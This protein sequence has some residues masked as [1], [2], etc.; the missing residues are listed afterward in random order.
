MKNHS[1]RLDEE[2]KKALFKAIEGV[3]GEVYLFG[4]RVDPEKRGGDVDLLI[5]TDKDPFK[6]SLEIST[7]YFM[8]C[9]EK[10]DVVVIDPQK[11]TEEQTAFLA[12]LE[13][14]RIR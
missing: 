4:S 6:I 8:E 3:S 13:M 5:F 10:T 2:Q 9:E 12:S 7:R 1:I 14:L 11:Q